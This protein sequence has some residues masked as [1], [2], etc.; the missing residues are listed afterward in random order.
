MT[1]VCE[2][3][4]PTQ[5]AL[6]CHGHAVHT[7]KVQLRAVSVSVTSNAFRN[8]GTN[9]TSEVQMRAVSV[10]VTSNTF[11]NTG[12]NYTSEVQLRAVSVSVTSNTFRNAGTN[13]T[14]EAQLGA[15]SVSVASTDQSLSEMLTLT[16]DSMCRSPSSLTL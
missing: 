1:E 9:C 7:S 10:S 2:A 6:V 4:L 14:S 16:S 5:Q 11:R 13:Y 15:V 8:T 12:T 3:I